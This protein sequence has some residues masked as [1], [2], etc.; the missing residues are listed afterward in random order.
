MRLVFRIWNRTRKPQG[1]SVCHLCKIN[2]RPQRGKSVDRQRLGWF[3]AAPEIPKATHL[4]GFTS[5][6][7]TLAP[8]PPPKNRF[9][10]PPDVLCGHLDHQVRRILQPP[11]EPRGQVEVLLSQ[12]SVLHRAPRQVA[13]E[14]CHQIQ[15]HVVSAASLLQVT[16]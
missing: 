9:A 10:K 7:E 1:M 13:P 12:Q 6:F 8:E 2:P 5:P 11:V 15:Q 4:I 16:V 14:R 3:M